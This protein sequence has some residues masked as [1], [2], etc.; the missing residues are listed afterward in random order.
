MKA[1]WAAAMAMAAT[2]GVTSGAEARISGPYQSGNLSVFLIDAEPAGGG[3]AGTY[4]TLDEAL[5]A[6]A[7]AVYETGDVNE[8]EV[9]NRSKDRTLFVQAG[10]IVK[11]GR[12]DRVLSV[13]LILPP[14]SGKTAITAFCVEQGRWSARAGESAQQFGSAEKSLAGKDLK[15]A[16]KSA[17]SQTEVWNAVAETQA[18]L[19]ASV[20]ADVAAP[21]SPTS[22]QLS[23][24]NK[25]KD[26]TLFIQ[27]GDIVKGGRQDRVLS[28]DLILPPGSGK[29]AIT[30]FCV[31]QGRWSARAGESA[32]QFASAEKSLAGKDL[33]LAA[34]SARS[35]TEVWSAVAETQAKLAASVGEEVASLASPTSLQLSLENKTLT[36]AI[37]KHKAALADLAESNPDA[38]GYVYA[39]NGKISGGDLYASP[40][41]FRKLWPRLLEASVTEAVAEA[42][43]GA[44]GSGAAADDV[45]A[46]L[47]AMDGAAS[48][49][50]E[51]PAGVTLV[52]RETE[53][54]AA[55]ETRSAAA[56]GWLHRSYI[57]K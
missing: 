51:L 39:I 47:A 35:Q 40:A 7:A 14:G 1:V 43:D 6:G 25:S 19:A 57:V 54:A 23:L 42:A 48:T 34:K 27:A 3:A 29:T 50:Q 5:A 49:A 52:S 31:E 56:E 10:D 44:A 37:G 4:L 12:Q 18:K 38:S 21:A 32:Q 17:R 55:F 26:R 45:A 41:L 11:G 24:E 36:E 20:G 46:F 16:A 53:K 13:D 2:M 8:L 22:L 15:L 9:E 33:K 28:V 30:A